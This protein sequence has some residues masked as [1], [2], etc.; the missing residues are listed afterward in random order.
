MWFCGD[1][2]VRYFYYH[3]WCR[4]FIIQAKDSYNYLVIP[5]GPYQECHHLSKL[6]KLMTVG[7]L[8]KLN[9][10][11]WNN[12]ARR[13]CVLTL[14]EMLL[15]SLRVI[16]E[17]LRNPCIHQICLKHTLTQRTYLFHDIRKHNCCCPVIIIRVFNQFSGIEDIINTLTT[18][19]SRVC[20]S[21]VLHNPRYMMKTN[22]FGEKEYRLKPQ[23]LYFG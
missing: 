19:F 23:F 15:Y 1:S 21:R 16:D 10:W 12:G 5:F 20:Y 18:Y 17:L 2:K 4:K 7:S 11:M 14:S 3:T 13:S 6:I 8:A 22:S 9:C